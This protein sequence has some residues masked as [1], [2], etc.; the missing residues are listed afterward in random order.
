MFRENTV[1]LVTGAAAG[2]GKATALAFARAG[3]DVVLADRDEP[4][5]RQAAAEVEALGRQ[6]LFVTTDMADAAQ[7]TALHQAIMARFGR[8]DIACNNAGIEGE[9]GATA[10]CSLANFD[11]VIAINLRGVFVCMKEQLAIMAAQGSGAIVNI[12]SVAGLVGFAG[13]P[14]YCAS[15]GGVVQLTRAAA[16]EYA[17]AG[18]RINAV[19]PGVVATEMID[20]MTG[21]QPEAE[22]EFAALQPMNR[23]GTT[24]EIAD[25]IV[26]LCSQAAGF[27][28][29]VAM[30]VDGGFVAR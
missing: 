10:D 3:C 15:K 4:R 19:C 14:A 22:A 5:G 13:V 11:R 2:I 1:A 23:M 24:Q 28:T 25:S 27:V 26:W 17:T 21:K 30:P 18:I 8:L 9:R 20:R 16:L 6:A 7:I 12:A 29:G